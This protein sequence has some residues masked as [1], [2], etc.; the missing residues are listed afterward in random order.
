MD[1]PSL[2]STI[3]KIVENSIAGAQASDFMF[4]TVI[5]IAPLTIQVDQKTSLKPTNTFL[6]LTPLVKDTK[7]EMELEMELTLEGRVYSAQAKGIIKRKNALKNGNRVLLIRQHGGQRFI[8]L[9]K[10]GE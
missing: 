1:N 2:I 10:V 3:Q 4:G 5:S 6:T 9:C 7:E 8:V